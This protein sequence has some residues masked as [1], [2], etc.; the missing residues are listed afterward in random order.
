MTPST[1]PTRTVMIEVRMPM[2]SAQR[3]PTM[4]PVNMSRLDT[5]VPRMPETLP[6]TTREGAVTTTLSLRSSAFTVKV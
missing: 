2:M 1:T 6:E 4:M 3:M 5:S